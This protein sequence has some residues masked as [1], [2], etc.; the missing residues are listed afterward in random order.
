VSLL[1]RGTV[2]PW[3]SVIAPPE[4]WDFLPTSATYGSAVP[5]GIYALRDHDEYPRLPEDVVAGLHP[6]K[7]GSLFR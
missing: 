2:W 3:C 5:L 6:S 7:Q 1:P 4:G